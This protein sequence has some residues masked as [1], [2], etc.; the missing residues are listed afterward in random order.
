MHHNLLGCL[1]EGLVGVDGVSGHGQHSAVELLEV[2]NPLAERG[3]GLGVDKVHGVEDENDILLSLVILQTNVANLSVDNG[4]GG[5]VWGRPRGLQE[6]LST[7]DSQNQKSSRSR[8]CDFSSHDNMKGRYLEQRHADS[9]GWQLWVP[10]TGRLLSA[11]SEETSARLTGTQ[12][13]PPPSLAPSLSLSK[14][15]H[16]PDHVHNECL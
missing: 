10:L 4:M 13:S 2:V 1:H 15:L 3:D 16:K 11:R 6:F 8:Y 14:R 12:R 7:S 5:E 9:C